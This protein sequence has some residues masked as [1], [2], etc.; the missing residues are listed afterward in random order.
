MVTCFCIT[1]GHNYYKPIQNKDLR[2]MKNQECQTVR[3]NKHDLKE[4]SQAKKNR[5]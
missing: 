5:P 4:A 1:R 2:N 3:K